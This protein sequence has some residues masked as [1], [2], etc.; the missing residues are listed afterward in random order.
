MRHPCDLGHRASHREAQHPAYG[1]GHHEARHGACAPVGR[2]QVSDP[3]RGRGRAHGLPDP[4]AQARGQQA[5]IAGGQAAQA[6]QPRPNRHAGRQQ[7][8]AAPAVRQPPQRQPHDG[9]QDRENSGQAAQLR[10]RKVELAPQRFE[11]RA[12][13]LAVVE[14]QNVDQKQ[15][16]EGIPRGC[17]GRAHVQN[18][19]AGGGTGGLVPLGGSGGTG[20]FGAA[21]SRRTEIVPRSEVSRMLGPWPTFPLSVAVRP[22]ISLWICGPKS[23][24]ASPRSEVACN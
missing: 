3:A 1:D 2:N 22:S 14:I 19:L 4:H 7:P 20:G 11:D 23:L 6:G 9:V 10:V 17:P 12:H 16:D 21:P 18:S 8:L 24:T 13:R 5:G 15:D